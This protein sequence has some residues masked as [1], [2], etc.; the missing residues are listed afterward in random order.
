MDTKKVRIE[1]A[2]QIYTTELIKMISEFKGLSADEYRLKLEKL[3]NEVVESL[4]KA[5]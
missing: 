3:Y 4:L 2:L 1:S 5:D